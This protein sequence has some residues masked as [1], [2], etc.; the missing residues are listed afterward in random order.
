MT[1][2][3]V[4]RY[5][6]AEDDA[7]A[8][9]LDHGSVRLVQVMG[10]D[11]DIVRAARVSYDN[12]SKLF[13]SERDRKLLWYLLKNKHTSPFEAVTMT[14]EICAPIFVL[15][16]WHRHRTWSY[17]EISAR[18][19]ELPEVCYVPNPEDITAQSDKNK[20]MRTGES[21]ELA[22]D[23]AKLMQA[24]NNVSFD[25]YRSLLE[26]GVPRELA[27]TV[28]PLSTYTRMYATVNLHN[29]FHFCRLRI[30]EHAQPEIRTYATAMLRLLHRFV[31]TA[32]ELFSLQ[33][34]YI[35]MRL[36]SGEVK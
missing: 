13:D 21:L 35:F 29:F 6:L 36:S 5:Q 30:H 10:G 24:H 11:V 17:N 7:S 26:Q 2:F 23:Y 33:D 27:R 15:R 32:A 28:L 3:R 4:D 14:W 12:D 8:A 34:S 16:Q 25:L 22:A 19:T 9:L 31:P 1:G 18:Y 20:Q